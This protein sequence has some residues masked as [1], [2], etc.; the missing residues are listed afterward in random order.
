MLVRHGVVVAEGWW[1]P[2]RAD[3]LH[4]LYSLSKSFT[5]TAVGLAVAE[6]RLSVDDPIG[7]F[8]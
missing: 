3:T 2:Y 5:A 6:G 1:H 4:L 7:K 8:F